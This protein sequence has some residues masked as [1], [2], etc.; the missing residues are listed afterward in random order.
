MQTKMEITTLIMNVFVRIQD[1]LPKSFV[2]L[3]K[4]NT[5]VTTRK[6]LYEHLCL[7]LKI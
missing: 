5:Y 3:F 1:D 4:N 7:C 6:H 2:F